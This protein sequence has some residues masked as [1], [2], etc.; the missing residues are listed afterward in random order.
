MRCSR[1]QEVGLPLVDMSGIS[2]LIHLN[3]NNN[4][5]IFF[6]L[7]IKSVVKSQQR[8][9][10][11]TGDIHHWADSSGMFWR[12]FSRLQSIYGFTN[13]KKEHKDVRKDVR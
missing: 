3:L 1:L 7:C 9:L 2:H 11:L 12:D 8:Q 6:V 5:N 10:L 13:G 4:L